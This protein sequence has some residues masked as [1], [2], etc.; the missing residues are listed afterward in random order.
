[1]EFVYFRSPVG[2]DKECETGVIYPGGWFTA[3]NYASRYRIGSPA[4]A[5]H[6]GHDLNN[7][8]L[9]WDADK[10]AAV[11]SIGDGEIV[12]AAKF[13]V[14]GNIIVARYILEDTRKIYVRYAHVDS[15]VDGGLMVKVGDKVMKG[16]QIARV[17]NAFD[18]MAYHLHWD[19]SPTDVLENKPADW[20]KLNLARLKANYV[21]PKLWLQSRVKQSQQIT[22]VAEVTATKLFIRSDA[23]PTATIVGS[24]KRGEHVKLQNAAPVVNKYHWQRLAYREPPQ[25]IA[26]EYTKPVDNE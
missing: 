7:N 9:H 10:L 17:G 1:M 12:H 25:W 21:D 4:E 18:T 22:R 11:Y 15:K 23:N 24:L 3:I 14:W 2:T 8:L 6:T 19:I 26:T 13:A 5:Y 16:Q 20:P